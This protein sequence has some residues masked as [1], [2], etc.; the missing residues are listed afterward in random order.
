MNHRVTQLL[1]YYSQA[2]RTL[3]SVTHLFG[4]K[5]RT[6]VK[7]ARRGNIQFSDLRRPPKRTQIEG[8]KPS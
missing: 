4:L 6:L 1:E 5:R 3:N 2:G 7:H 8:N